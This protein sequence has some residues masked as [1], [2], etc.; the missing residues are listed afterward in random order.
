MVRTLVCVLR[1]DGD[2]CDAKFT[3]T[4]DRADVTRLEASQC[5]GW[6][7]VMATQR[8][9]KQGVAPSVDL[10]PSCAAKELDTVRSA[11]QKA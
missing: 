10:C 9:M 3:G 4:S 11:G 5:H 6:V 8:L 2:S 1:C 7:H